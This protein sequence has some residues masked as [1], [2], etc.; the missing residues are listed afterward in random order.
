M[1]ELEVTGNSPPP[2]ALCDFLQQAALPPDAC[3]PLQRGQIEILRGLVI[4]RVHGLVAGNN[5]SGL[6]QANSIEITDIMKNSRSHQQ[7]AIKAVEK[8]SVPG[9]SCRHVFESQITLDR[10]KSQ[11][12]E[13]SGHADQ[14]SK[15][16]Q[17]ERLSENRAR[18]HKAA[19]NHH[20]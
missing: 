11:I 8:T 10:G 5:S 12:T 7:Q 6:P 20:E 19:E 17:V 2:A 16:D 3:P 13:L 15:H 1:V 9:K 14:D 18:E 4:P